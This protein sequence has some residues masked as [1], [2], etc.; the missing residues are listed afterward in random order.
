MKEGREGGKYQRGTADREGRVGVED[1]HRSVG[2]EV[3]RQALK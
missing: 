1:Q 2:M 3:G